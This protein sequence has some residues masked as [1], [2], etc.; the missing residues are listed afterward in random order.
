MYMIK[1]RD[2]TSAWGVYHASLGE[3]KYLQLETTNAEATDT[4]IWNNTAPTS[5]VLSLGNAG[6]FN[7]ASGGTY[8]C[9]A[10]AEK[11]GYSKFGSYTSN[12]NADG[13]FIYTGFKPALVLVK[14]ASSTAA[15]MLYDNKRDVDN[16]NTKALM[17]N[18]N[19]AE[20]VNAEN[21]DFLSNGFK[22]RGTGVKLNNSTDK[23]IYMAFAEAPLVGSNN[24]PCTAR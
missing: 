6:Y 18:L 4:G 21:V 22:C 16:P 23:F 24:V 7:N 13:P 11:K 14:N 9:Y 2:S 10:F 1:R 3:N 12:G 17:P 8:V 19:N 5:T 20:D 15:W